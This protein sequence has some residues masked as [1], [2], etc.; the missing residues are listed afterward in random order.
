MNQKKFVRIM[1]LI[2]AGVMVLS[3]ITMIASYAM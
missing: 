2:L 1:A 3:F